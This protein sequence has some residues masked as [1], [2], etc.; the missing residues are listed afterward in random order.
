MRKQPMNIIAFAATKGG[1]G[2]TTLATALAVR[3]AKESK[4]VALL[5]LDPQEST[6]AWCDRR[7]GANPKLFELD[8]TAEAIEL[9]A[10]EGWRWV[11]IDTGPARIEQRLDAFRMVDCELLGHVAAGHQKTFNATGAGAEA[12]VLQ[13]YPFQLASYSVFFPTPTWAKAKMGKPPGSYQR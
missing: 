12:Q 11:F 13:S 6:A 9:L 5:D 10:S 2:K 1:V 8:A 7:K 3:A 4:K